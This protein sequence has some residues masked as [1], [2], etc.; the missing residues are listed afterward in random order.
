MP[1]HNT[2]FFYGGKIV[3]YLSCTVDIYHSSFADQATFH[4]NQTMQF[5]FFLHHTWSN[6]HH[7]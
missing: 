3:W 5:I 7:T 4:V 6:M 1:L 2:P